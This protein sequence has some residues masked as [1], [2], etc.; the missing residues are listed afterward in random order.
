[1][2]DLP[3][4]ERLAKLRTLE[5]WLDWQLYDTRRKIHA[6]EQAPTGPAS[7]VVEPKRHPTHPEPAR[8]HLADCTMPQRKTLPIEASAAR[9]G[10]TEDP[11][12]VAACE[13]CAPERRLANDGA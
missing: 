13:F 5:A 9:L 4:A 10:L 2:S 1:M 8:I 7:Y 12:S 6:L 11:G 3:P